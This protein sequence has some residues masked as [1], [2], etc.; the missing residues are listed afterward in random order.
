[1]ED[2]SRDVQRIDRVTG[3]IQIQVRGKKLQIY[4]CEKELFLNVKTFE[5]RRKEERNVC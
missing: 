5:R 1:M 4:M 3:R 2:R